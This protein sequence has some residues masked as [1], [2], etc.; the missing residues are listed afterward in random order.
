MATGCQGPYKRGSGGF[1]GCN[2]GCC[3]PPCCCNVAVYFDCGAPATD[4]FP[5]GCEFTTPECVPTPLWANLDLPKFESIPEFSKKPIMSDDK[6]FIFGQGAA[7]CSVPCETVCVP[8]YCDNATGYPC[9]CI[10]IDN[11]ILYSVGNGYIGAPDTVLL[12]EGCDTSFATVLINGS[13]APVFVCDG[14]QINV[15]LQLDGEV[16]C[17]CEPV[18]VSCCPCPTVSMS[19]AKPRR[20]LWRSKIDSLGKLRVNPLT[21]KPFIQLNKT[22][23]LRR[24]KMREI[25]LKSR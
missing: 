15:T 14:E 5:A 23:L 18:G 6:K 7:T 13:P 20:A 21:R 25:R 2:C 12:P 1:C 8:I 17:C 22:E 3:P 9:C 24:I 4:S 16:C 19:M 10:E 11:G